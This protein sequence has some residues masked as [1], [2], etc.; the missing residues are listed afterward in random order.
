[1]ERRVE[2]ETVY[3][4]HRARV[5][6]RMNHREAGEADEH[7]RLPFIDQALCMKRLESILSPPLLDLLGMLRNDWSEWAIMRRT[8]WS[9]EEY[10]YFYDD[11]KTYAKSIF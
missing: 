6:Y 11:L 2:R 3:R 7:G 8:G 1:M 9:K 4:N 5:P 10:Q